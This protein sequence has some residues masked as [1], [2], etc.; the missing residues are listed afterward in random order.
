MQIKISKP[1][2][3]ETVENYTF[4]LL[5]D[6]SFVFIDYEMVQKT[7][8]K[9]WKSIKRWNKYT[10]QYSNIEEPPLPPEIRFSAKEKIISLI[11][12]KTWE[13]YKPN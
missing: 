10:S 8:K 9:K 3:N 4:V 7:M 1:I 6:L 2:N 13:E 11:K 5:D 12:I